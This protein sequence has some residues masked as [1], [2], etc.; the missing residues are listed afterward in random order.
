MKCDILQGG[1][2]A[3]E[4]WESFNAVYSHK[5]VSYTH[6]DVYKR[7]ILYRSLQLLTFFHHNICQ[8]I[9]SS[10]PSSSPCPTFC[11]PSISKFCAQVLLKVWPIQFGFNFTMVFTSLFTYSPKH[12]LF[13]YF[14]CPANLIIFRHNHK[15][16]IYF[17]SLFLRHNTSKNIYRKTV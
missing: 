1:S 7:Q 16:P 14:L 8:H 10:F 17:F 15:L 6:L 5:A 9:I 3:W 11:L 13:C 12:F 4:G 2:R